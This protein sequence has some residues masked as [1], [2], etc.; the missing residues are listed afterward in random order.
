MRLDDVFIILLHFLQRYLDLFSI[1]LS[2]SLVLG[3]EAKRIQFGSK[4]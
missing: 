1:W 3:L 2:G 4:I